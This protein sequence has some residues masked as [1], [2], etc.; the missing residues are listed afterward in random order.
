ML[1]EQANKF[2]KPKR[3]KG[4]NRKKKLVYEGEIEKE[5]LQENEENASDNDVNL[6][7]EIADFCE[8]KEFM[9]W[10]ITLNY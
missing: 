6:D 7:N 9:N 1:M 3:N 4:G 10:I 2:N 5:S 8:E